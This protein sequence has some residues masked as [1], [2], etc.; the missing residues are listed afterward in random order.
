MNI[1][2]I[3]ASGEGNGSDMS[4]NSRSGDVK[5]KLSVRQQPEAAR[6][7]GFG[8]LDRRTIDPPPIIQLNV[9][10]PD[11]SESDIESHLRYPGYVM[12]CF[13]RD[14]SG[15]LDVSSMPQENWH[16]KRSKNKRLLGQDVSTPFFGEDDLGHEG[17]FFYF[18]DLSCRTTGNFKLHFCLTR[19]GERDAK[20]GQHIPHLAEVQSDV[21]TVYTAKEFPGMQASTGL[22]RSLKRHGCVIT[23]RKDPDRSKNTGEKNSTSDE[24]PDDDEGDM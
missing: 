12:Q 6:A 14:E 9:Q 10:G 21:F 16:Q 13:I 8:D 1:R 7:C 18:D 23:I 4:I 15:C 24:E 3:A 2:D 5:F 20:D 22:A 19:V 11:F 17:C